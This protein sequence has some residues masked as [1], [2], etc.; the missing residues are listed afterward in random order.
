MLF[1]N[2]SLNFK[3]VTKFAYIFSSSDFP[4]DFDR[5]QCVRKEIVCLFAQGIASSTGKYNEG[6]RS[7]A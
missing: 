7:A 2:K 6:D 3:K 1:Q 4:F 5:T